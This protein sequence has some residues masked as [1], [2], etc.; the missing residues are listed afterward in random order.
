M[1]T[2]L[3]VGIGAGNPDFL[4]LQAISA[5][6]RADVVFLPDKGEEKSGLNALRLRILDHAA[7]GNRCRTVAFRSPARPAQAPVYQEGIAGWRE[8][9]VASYRQLFAASLAENETGAF[10]VW[11]DPSLYDGTLAALAE[12]QASGMSIAI[13]TIPGISAV[14]ALAAAHRI[15][16]NRIGEPV[17]VTTGRRVAA[18]EADRL[19]SFVVMLDSHAGWER[20]AGEPA[21][22]YWGAYLGTPDELLVAGPVA[23]VKDE[24]ARLRSAARARHGWIM[25]TYL[26]RRPT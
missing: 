12:L 11:G 2:I 25:D 6:R 19:S 14:Q 23:E 3:I 26:I 18:G 10:L 4:T 5:I 24:I 13:E 1:R 16:L 8:A 22:I 9:L 21:E 20:F 17:T 7:P 15:P